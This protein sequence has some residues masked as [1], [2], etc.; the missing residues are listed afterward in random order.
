MNGLEPKV[1]R[2]LALDGDNAVE[3]LVDVVVEDSGNSNPDGVMRISDDKWIYTL[4][5]DESGLQ[6]YG[7]GCYV[8]EFEI[9]L[10]D[11]G[12]VYVYGAFKLK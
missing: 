2:I 8:A 12:T 9:S 4:D 3:E 7:P 1:T 6:G 10:P 11:N 5:V